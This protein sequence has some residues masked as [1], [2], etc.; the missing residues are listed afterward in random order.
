MKA[1]VSRAAGAGFAA[2]FKS[3]KALR[4]DRPIHPTGAAL[5]GTIERSPGSNGS[6]IAWTD[7][8]G[9]DAVEARLSRS[10]GTPAGW[11]DILGLAIRVPTDSGPADLLLASTGMSPAGRW[12]L[13]PRRDAGPGTFTSLMP[14]KGTNGA[15]LLAALPEPSGQRLPATPEAFRKALGTGTWI[16]GLYHATPTG[17]WTRF[18]TLTLA[19]DPNIDDTRTRYD[20]TAHPLPGAGTYQWAANL[21]APAYA[22]ARRTRPHP[23]Q[24]PE[25]KH[26]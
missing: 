1:S 16:L 17:P 5:T 12:F 25:K 26:P 20:P 14:Y 8:P 9:S 19:T 11:P 23:Q 22:T 18:G 21:R 6:G 24:S 15:V 3:L 4:P 10:L 7:S 2:L 13:L